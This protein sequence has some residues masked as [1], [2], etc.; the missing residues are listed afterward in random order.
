MTHGAGRRAAITIDGDRITVAENGETREVPLGSPE[1]FEILSRLWIRSGWETKYVYGFTWLGRPIIQLPEDIVRAQELLHE[2]TPDVVIETGVAHGGSLVLYASLLKALGK[3]RV[4][5]VDIEIRPH[6]REAIEAHVL[7]PGI[8]LI[9][10]D[11]IAPGTVEKV[12]ALV[13]PDEKV[14][15]ILDSHHARAH[16]LAELRAYAPMVTPGSYALVADGIMEDLVGASRTRPEWVTDN[17]RAAAADFVKENDAFVIVDP[18]FPFNEG[19]VRRRI[20]Y[21]KG[22]ILRRVR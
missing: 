7:A 21:W 2:V 1:G 10:G 3:G 5:G 6:N 12:R 19:T 16:V 9:E 11:A 20:T 17:P 22:G 14:M 4:I 18:P 13:R 8:T 15:L